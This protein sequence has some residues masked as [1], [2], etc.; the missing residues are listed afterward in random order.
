[1]NKIKNYITVFLFAIAAISVNAAAPSAAKVVSQA[2]Q[3]LKSEKSVE[4]EFT[5]RSGNNSTNGSITIANR[6][7]TLKS[8]DG[9]TWYD[10]KNLW[11][12]SPSTNEV[13]L[14]EPTPQELAEINPFSFIATLQSAYTYRLLQSPA[15]TRCVE[16]NLKKNENLNITKAVI[17]FDDTTHF[18][19]KIVLTIDRRVLT[20]TVTKISSGQTLPVSLFKFSADKYPGAEVIDL[21]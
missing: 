14:S 5:V 11:S 15:G 16:F 6:M 18:P 21:R 1:M 4:A 3:K 10:G 19:K 2:V 13:N 17:T 20:V 9:S 8:P 7:F 12:Y